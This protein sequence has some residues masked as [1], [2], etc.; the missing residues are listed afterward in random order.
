MAPYPVRVGVGAVIVRDGRLLLVQFD[1][2]GYIHTNLPGGG[3]HEGESLHAALRREVMEET[4]AE[5]DID[6]MLFAVENEPPVHDDVLHDE[7]HTLKL[8]FHCELL[9]GSEPRL[10]DTPDPMETA[11]RWVPLE[12]LEGAGLLGASP[13]LI[14]QALAAKLPYD[15]YS[16]LVR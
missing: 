11:V 1:D 2:D 10:P 4:A 5:V 9:D 14:R 7:V 13:A 16:D 8:F 3:V 15:P 6:P 12:E